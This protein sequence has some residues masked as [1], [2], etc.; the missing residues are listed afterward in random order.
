MEIWQTQEAKAKLTELMN[1][2]K[3][4]PQIISRRGINEIVMMNIK[5]YEKLCNKK[6]DIVSFFKNSPLNNLE[7][8]FERDKSPTRDIEF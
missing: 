3:I 8:E 5:D 7:I 1:K 4:R 2:A 6:E